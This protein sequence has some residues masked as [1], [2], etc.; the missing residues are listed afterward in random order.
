[1]R[2]ADLDFL[3]TLGLGSVSSVAVG[4]LSEEG[5]GRSL[6]GLGVQVC[7]GGLM[8]GREDEK[9]WRGDKGNMLQ[10]FQSFQAD[11]ELFMIVFHSGRPL[12]CQ[13]KSLS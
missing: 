1:M 12:F 3:P 10:A 6:R 11:V 8:E 2:I 5:I 9:V 7:A 13:V 4:P